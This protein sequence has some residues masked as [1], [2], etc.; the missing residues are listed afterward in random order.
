MTGRRPLRAL[1]VLLALE[2]AAVAVLVVLG[3]ARHRAT[4]ETRRTADSL[5]AELMLTDLALWTEAS[6][7]R[8]PSQAD[9]FAPHADHPS[10]MEHFPAGS[11]VP[12]P[13]EG[14]VSLMV[15]P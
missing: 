2:T 3:E 12:P 9:R 4:E 6:Y 8:H 10:A 1:L 13:D 11:M 5:A 15:A 7:C 14:A